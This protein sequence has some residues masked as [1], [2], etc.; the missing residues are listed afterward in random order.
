MNA[1][2]GAF[3]KAGFNRAEMEAGAAA[4]KFIQSGGTLERWVAVYRASAERMSGMGQ[5]EVAENGPH[6]GAQTR[7]PNEDGGAASSVPQGHQVHAPSSSPNRGGEG[8]FMVASPGQV[9]DAIPA[10]ETKPTRAPIDFGERAHAIKNRLAQSVLD[11][12]KT[13]DGRAW[14]DVHAYEL[15]SM[16]RD[17]AFAQAIKSHVGPLSNVQS[18]MKIR[19]LINAETFEAIRS[20]V[21]GA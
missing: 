4:M 18:G 16:A 7:Q 2:A 6:I 19:D 14:G 3:D 1:M 13:N 21:H 10:R 11:R 5:K 8:H 12:I 15:E 17:G 20:K 9:K